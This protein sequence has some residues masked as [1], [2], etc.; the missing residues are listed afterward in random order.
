MAQIISIGLQTW[1]SPVYRAPYVVMKLKIL[2]QSQTYTAII[3]YTSGVIPVSS[4]REKR[5]S[6]LRAPLRETPSRWRCRLLQLCLSF[7]SSMILPIRV[8]LLMM[9]LLVVA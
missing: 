1:V 7:V 5:Y 4:L 9:L 6:P 8:G 3:T 2:L